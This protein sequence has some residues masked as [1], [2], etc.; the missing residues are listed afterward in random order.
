MNTIKKKTCGV[1]ITYNPNIKI[2]HKLIASIKSQVDFLLIIDNGSDEDLKDISNENNITF[3]PLSE[4]FGIAHAQNVGIKRARDYC[5]NYVLLL[6]QDSIPAPDMVE[7]LMR[8]AEKLEAEGQK[9]AAV[10]PSYSDVRQG[11][12]PS[13]VYL[14][15]L[16][17]HRRAC[18][19]PEATVPVDFLIASGSLLPMPSLDLIGGMAEEL[20]IDY[21]DIEWGLRAAKLGFSSFGVCNAHMEHALGD[22]WIPYKGRKIPL[23]SPLRHYYHMRNAIW[24]ARQSWISRAWTTV[25]IWRVIR[26]FAFFSLFAPQGYRHAQ[27][28]A[29]GLWHGIGGR[30]GRK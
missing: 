19:D 26:Q 16:S 14:K 4:N 25:L 18:S 24:L 17:L 20:F 21:V 15:G 29:I 6:D 30:M 7:R 27:M 22:D 13:F 11:E 9:V 10:G 2:L 28:M 1:I 12:I 8:A 3:I 5:A 23:H